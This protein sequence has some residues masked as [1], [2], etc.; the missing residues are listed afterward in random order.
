[1]LGLYVTG[2]PVDKYSEQLR[3]ANTSVI[4]DLK[5]NEAAMNGRQVVVAGEVVSLRKIVTKN[6]D[7]M[8]VIHLEDWHDSAAALDVVIFPR[9][10]LTC[11]EI[12]TEGEILRVVGKF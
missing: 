12:V 7:M 6:G 2:R 8:C 5:E 1:L 11:Q 9:T 4:A 3:F 10:W